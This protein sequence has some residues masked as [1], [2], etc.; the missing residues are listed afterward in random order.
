M[1]WLG[2]FIFV[3]AL[4]VQASPLS[5][6]SPEDSIVGFDIPGRGMVQFE[7]KPT[8][9]LSPE[10]AAQFP[11]IKTYAGTSAEAPDLKIRVEKSPLGLSAQIQSTTNTIYIDPIAITKRP[12]KDSLSGCFRC[13]T[14]T[15]TA[16][17]FSKPPTNSLNG[18]STQIRNFRIAIAA[19][20]EYTAYHGGT[21]AN[22]LAAIATVLNRVNELYERELGVHLTLVANNNLVVFTDKDTDP[23]TD[24]NPSQTT[25]EQGQA[26][27]DLLIG[28]ANYDVGMVFNTGTYGLAHLGAVCN[29]QVKGSACM[30][31]PNPVGEIFA[32]FVA[33]EMAHQFGANH[34]FNSNQE[35]CA[36]NRNSGTAVE[37]GAGSTLMSYAGICPGDSFQPLMDRYFHAQSL[38]EISNF[39]NN[40]AACATITSITNQLPTLSIATSQVIPQLTPF[41]LS[42]TASDADGDPVLLNWDQMDLGS[43]QS[44]TNND[45]GFSP[46]FRS[47]PPTTNQARTFPSLTNL[48]QNTAPPGE[49][50]PSTA[51]TLHFRVTARDGRNIGA[52]TNI[53]T[54]VQVVTSA[55]PFRITSHQLPGTYV[56]QQTVQWDVA[57]TTNAS[58]GASAVNI[59]LSTNGGQSF[60]IVLATNTPNDGVQTVTFP[61]INSSSSRLKVQPVGKVFF[62]INSNSFAIAPQTSI[63]GIDKG[64]NSLT[65]NWTFTSGQNYKLQASPNLEAPNWQDLAVTITTN[66]AN[67]Q[68]TV[69]LLSSKQFFRIRQF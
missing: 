35:P 53:D 69:P 46:L 13:L 33:H 57:G 52:T 40:S 9:V 65:V 51:R 7:L 29:P 17:K 20:G 8:Q 37:P 62:A 28:S 41:T 25:I 1:R 45:N 14:P 18:S 56:G 30:G 22:A 39:L 36:S 67:L 3:Y 58:V 64:T 10:L 42:A 24:N 19:T 55:G 15:T 49:K 34:T 2:I 60:P 66:G 48:L 54:Q 16:S 47:F 38:Q 27:F 21:V 23:F 68:A 61:T 43:A 11:N 12:E 5:S 6:A 26:T 50:L 63:T 32:I 59:L 44:W 4:A 31:L